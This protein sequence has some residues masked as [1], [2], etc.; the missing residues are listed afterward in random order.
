MAKSKFSISFPTKIVFV[1]SVILACFAVYRF[2]YENYASL[3]KRKE[4]ER[5]ADML[6]EKQRGEN[7]LWVKIN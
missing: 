7:L 2:N 1:S 5:Q 4:L 3:H 6:Y